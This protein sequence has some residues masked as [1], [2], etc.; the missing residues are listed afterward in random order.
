LSG[1]VGKIHG[2]AQKSLLKQT[3]ETF[4]KARQMCNTIGVIDDVKSL[5]HTLSIIDESGDLEFFKD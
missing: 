5:I 1:K 2:Q 3:K 4:R